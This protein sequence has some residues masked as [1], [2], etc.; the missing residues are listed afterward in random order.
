MVTVNVVLFSNTRAVLV[1]VG[2]GGVLMVTLF[3]VVLFR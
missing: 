2:P 3:K 1:K